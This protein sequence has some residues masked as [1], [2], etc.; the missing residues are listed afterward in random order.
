MTWPNSRLTTY[1]AN[2]PVKAAD[3]NQIQDAIIDGGK[4][5]DRVAVFNVA[6]A[7]GHSSPIETQ[8]EI[9]SDTFEWHLPMH[10]GDRVKE[11]RIRCNDTVGSEISCRARTNTDGTMANLGA[12]AKVSDS[13]GWQTIT[14]DDIGQVT[15]TETKGITVQVTVTNGPHSITY[16]SVTYDHP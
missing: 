6:Q 12:A 7:Y 2:A 13:S 11:I 10:S 8:L 15:V 5:G 3:L 14:L 16:M 9:T 1:T 4:H